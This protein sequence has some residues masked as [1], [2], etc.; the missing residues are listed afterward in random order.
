MF[1]DGQ[2]EIG[3]I[4][5]PIVQLALEQINNSESSVCPIVRRAGRQ[6]NAHTQILSNNAFLIVPPGSIPRADKGTILRREAY[7]GFEKGIAKVYLT[8]DT[9]IDSL[10][11]IDM[12]AMEQ[13]LKDLIQTRLS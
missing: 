12:T 5:E 11:S 2:F 13:N 6:M 7:R 4:L 8:I 3:V 10:P 1:G 9:A